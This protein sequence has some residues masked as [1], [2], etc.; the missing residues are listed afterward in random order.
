MF[1]VYIVGYF[2]ALVI[3]P[4]LLI[5]R[6]GVG[7]FIENNSCMLYTFDYGYAGSINFYRNN[8]NLPETFSL[9]SSFLM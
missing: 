8:Y 6:F 1:F 2:N 5:K 4:I 9:Y 7:A 3:L